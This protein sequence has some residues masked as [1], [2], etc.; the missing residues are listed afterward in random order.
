LAGINYLILLAQKKE[1]FQKVLFAGKEFII[2]SKGEVIETIASPCP[3][4]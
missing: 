3:E 2:N 1:Q 4:P